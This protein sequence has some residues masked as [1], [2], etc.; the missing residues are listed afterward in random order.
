MN[1]FDVKLRL[2]VSRKLSVRDKSTVM[3]FTF[4]VAA[5]AILLEVTIESQSAKLKSFE[6]SHK[7]GT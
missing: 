5:V 1:L 4:W 3:N 7:S 6:L 2:G